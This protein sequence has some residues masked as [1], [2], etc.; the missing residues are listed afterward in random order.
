MHATQRILTQNPI[1][2]NHRFRESIQ[3]KQQ[4]NNL[5]WLNV[6]LFDILQSTMNYVLQI[7][8]FMD[9]YLRSMTKHTI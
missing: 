4:T 7:T 2:Q 8:S 9:P 3:E 6:F 5:S 1:D